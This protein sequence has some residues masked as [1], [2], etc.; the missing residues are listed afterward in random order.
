MYNMNDVV[1]VEETVNSIIMSVR[2]SL[3]DKTQ[4]SLEN[5]KKELKQLQSM[6][7]TEEDNLEEK[8]QFV[9]IILTIKQ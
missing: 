1:S 3:L 4:T 7:Q 8:K 2:K 5:R 6:I 9:L